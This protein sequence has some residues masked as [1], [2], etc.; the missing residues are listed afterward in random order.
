MFYKPSKISAALLAFAL[1][2]TTILAGCGNDEESSETA[3]S[4]SYTFSSQSSSSQ[5]KSYE[6]KSAENIPFSLSFQE[7]KFEGSYSGDVNSKNVPDGTGVFTGTPDGEGKYLNYNGSFTNGSLSGIG[8]LDTNNYQ[9]SFPN[10]D[11][12][13]T[14]QTGSYN[15]SVKRG[16]PDGEGSFSATNAE[17]ISYTYTGSFVDG[18][19]N[20]QG[21][22]VFDSPDT[23]KAPEI[24]TFINGYFMPTLAEAYSYLGYTDES[25]YGGYDVSD[26]E[27]ATLDAIESADDIDDYI[28]SIL[29][30]DL[31]YNTY[32]YN[33]DEFGGSAVA[34]TFTVSDE[35][36][37]AY[38]DFFKN[39]GMDSLSGQN[40]AGQWIQARMLTD[41]FRAEGM[42][43]GIAPGARITVYGIP[44]GYTYFSGTDVY[45]DSNYNARTRVVEIAMFRCDVN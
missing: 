38:N 32:T 20:G 29:D 34:W 30:P 45:P 6:K 16:R 15:G 31:S 21:Q 11:G 36:G 10:D 2:L 35:G 17:G 27:K 44:L 13:T 18:L 3:T 1:S 42:L 25:S 24:G 39:Y 43:S 4:H 41:T 9:M 33:P 26:A 8:T 5:T 19:F 23:P 22:K 14:E 40:D 28:D 7:K 12:T 37:A